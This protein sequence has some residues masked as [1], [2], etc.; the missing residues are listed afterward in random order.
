MPVLLVFLAFGP[1]LTLPQTP[2]GRAEVRFDRWGIPHIFA[3][4]PL[5]LSYAQGYVTALQRLFQM[6]FTRRKA[7]GRLAEWLGEGAVEGD[8]E[9]RKVGLHLAARK[10]LE[11]LSLEALNLLEAYAKGVNEAA[12]QMAELPPEYQRLGAKFSPWKPLDSVAL[13]KGIAWMLSSSVEEEASIY[14]ALLKM[15]LAR[16]LDLVRAEPTDP[17]SIVD[18]SQL[19]PPPGLE[20]RSIPEGAGGLMREVLSE[21]ARGWLRARGR[22]L[23]SNNFAI[24]PWRTE[25]GLPIVANDPH[26]GLSAPPVWHLVHLHCPQFKLWGATIPGVPGVIIGT[27]GRIAWAV[28]STGFDVCDLYTFRTS[29]AGRA[30]IYKGQEVPFKVRTEKILVKGGRVVERKVLETHL[31]PVVA[32]FGALVASVRWVGH[33]PTKEV[34]AFLGLY[35]ARDV[36]E[37]ERAL[38]DFACPP[39]NF[40]VADLKGN[41]FFRANG[42][43]P[44]RKG[45]PFLPMNGETGEFEWEGF[46]PWEELPQVLNPRSGIVVTANNRPQRSPKHYLAFSF[47]I[48]FRARRLW[49]LL[50]VPWRLTVGYVKSV[51]CDVYSKLAQR[52]L[53]LLIKSAMRRAG[54]LG[55]LERR[56]IKALKE[57]NGFCLPDSTGPT[58]FHAWLRFALRGAFLDELPEDL[59]VKFVGFA[60]VSVRALISAFE[61]RTK[62]DW[63]D[64]K[65]TARREGPEDLAISALKEAVRWLSSRLGPN[66]KEWTWGRLCKV[67]AL[68]PLFEDFSYKASPAPGGLFTVSPGGFSVFGE[69]F[70]FSAGASVRLI[71]QLGP[72]G[73]KVWFSLPGGQSGLPHSKHFSDLLPT[74]LRGD[75]FYLEG[76][77]A[78]DNGRIT[79][80]SPGMPEGWRTFPRKRSFCSHL[81]PLLEEVG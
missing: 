29:R 15:G 61:G 54:E 41:I 14:L 43:L 10:M 63:L 12:K 8:F 32:K 67:R 31:G 71:I 81:S 1:K 44:L 58:V 59:G 5:A 75:Y 70:S 35:K 72:E 20:P 36:F 21:V 26:L 16:L 56:A 55:P 57:W 40:V 64:D 60:N 66:P 53:P 46:I 48:G 77:K 2:Y 3:E 18:S 17:I 13:I 65:R 52:L 73:P 68:H 7:E 9:V 34:D 78:K 69:D 22:T 23:G 11:A 30:Y 37:A 42:L 39:Q 76:G 62:F 27:N 50:D 38:R 79:G 28:T 25:E 24:A 33:E 19:A 74:W 80:L 45:T 51:Q 47:D 4:N 49:E 6:D